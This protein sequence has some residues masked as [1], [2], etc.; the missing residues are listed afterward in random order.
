MAPGENLNI[1]ATFSGG[2]QVETGISAV[3]D[4][5]KKTASDLD[6]F[7]DALGSAGG[8][9]LAAS[10]SRAGDSVGNMARD[11][12][13][14]ERA[15]SS[16]L[17]N[18]VGGF[19]LV[20]TSAAAA[21]IA[22]GGLVQAAR[23]IEQL[24]RLGGE[25]LTVSASFQ[26]M[27]SSVGVS[28]DLLYRMQEAADGTIS[29]IKLLSLANYSMIGV[30]G[31]VGN[32][33]GN[34]NDRLIEIARAAFKAR[35]SLQSVEFAYQSLVDGIKR[36][37]KRLVD[38]LGLQVKAREANERYAASV[39]KS[40]NELTAEEVQLA[41]LNE[42]LRAGGILIQQVGGDVGTI[43]DAFSRAEAAVENFRVALGEKL[44]PAV[45][46]A[47]DA[48][49][50]F[51]TVLTSAITDEP[52]DE[53]T[54]L[55][56]TLQMLE[57][58]HEELKKQMAD[59]SFFGKVQAAWME[60]A[61]VL[62]LSEQ[63]IQETKD[64]IIALE[65][66][67][68]AATFATYNA[69][70]VAREYAA[71]LS[72][73]EKAARDTKAALDAY[74][75]GWKLYW[76]EE[77]RINDEVAKARER[78][79]GSSVQSLSALGASYVD[80]AAAGKEY[81]DTVA[82]LTEKWERGQIGVEEYRYELGQAELKL[83]DVRDQYKQTTPEV[84]KFH[85]ALRG[86]VESNLSASFD[87]AGL[88]PELGL[89]EDEVDEHYRR[90][91]AIALRGQEELDKHQDD[92]AD[93]LAEIPEDVRAQGIEAIQAW[94][95]DKVLAYDKGLDFSLI[96][97]DTL[98]KR[99][100]EALLA[101]EMKRQ[102]V[103]EITAELGGAVSQAQVSAAA[104]M[105]LGGTPLGQITLGGVTFGTAE[106]PPDMSAAA[107]QISAQ[108]N[109]AFKD[110]VDGQ[111]MLQLTA[112][113][114]IGADMKSMY[115]AGQVVGTRTLSGI[116]DAVAQGAPDIINTLANAIA[117]SVARVLAQQNRRTG[118]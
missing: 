4:V 118:Q 71:D 46:K 98:K 48:W 69:K 55:R 49:A 6:K 33:I 54:V 24:G 73:V 16:G 53:L 19:G 29:T 110:K 36:V 113:S 59:E 28:T 22:I 92:W 37:E 102:L 108:L 51:L 61:G 115:A 94:A 74:S 109:A 31:A 18:L 43:N 106:E 41:F 93:T 11:F 3:G 40:V 2:K 44:A 32:A 8:R 80:A 97:R 42:T 79:L 20:A 82:D 50:N 85:D 1:S 117:P 58:Q 57:D 81:A 34:A 84:D 13:L 88:A 23:G 63:E 35:P 86:L 103:D 45:T 101:E 75:E 112:A 114:I 67:L 60:W 65:M 107:E 104:S 39:G 56:N 5:A 68:N 96:N 100:M 111:G 14:M 87:V 10:A 7:H 99:I 95:K 12:A 89:R 17:R 105:A 83:R 90:L 38:N 116:N 78:A 77:N 52:E 62:D 25:S 72:L 15:G 30:T 70:R 26:Q 27:T 66:E 9:G 21:G 76:E 64:A 91:A 47:Q